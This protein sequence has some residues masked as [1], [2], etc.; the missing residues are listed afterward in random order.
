MQRC[1]VHP[2]NALPQPLLQCQQ[3]TA[4]LPV[5]QSSITLPRLNVAPDEQQVGNGPRTV[6]ADFQS[7]HTYVLCLICR[8]ATYPD[9]FNL[10]N[11]FLL[12]ATVKSMASICLH[13]TH[14]CT[15]LFDLNA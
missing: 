11:L 9:C 13:D 2:F 3:G 14:C 10:P 6:L 1:E 5:I 7:Y 4:S 12:T 8:L 15:L